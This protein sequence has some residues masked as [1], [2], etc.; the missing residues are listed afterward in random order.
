M[1]RTAEQRGHRCFDAVSGVR[2]SWVTESSRTERNCSLSRGLSAAEFFD[3]AR[4]LDGDRYQAA[5]ASKV[6]AKVPNRRRPCNYHTHP[7]AERHEGQLATASTGVHAQADQLEIARFQSVDVGPER[8]TSLRL[9][10]ESAAD[11]ISNDST[12]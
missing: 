12:M 3:R 7:H 8:Y 9:D 4:A 1:S 5:M 10:K 6:A 2:N 11:R